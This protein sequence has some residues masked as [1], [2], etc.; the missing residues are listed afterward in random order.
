MRGSTEYHPYIS[1][2]RSF[3]I[4]GNPDQYSQIPVQDGLSFPP[5]PQALVQ[6]AETIH[7]PLH[8]LSENALPPHW[9]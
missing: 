4:Q 7:K 1:H 5:A 6:L 2:I 9:A 3:G 8:F